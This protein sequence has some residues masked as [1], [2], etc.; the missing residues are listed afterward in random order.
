MSRSTIVGAVDIGTSKVMVLVAE[1]TPSR[2]MNIIGR[3]QSTTVGVKKGEIIDLRSVSDSV[4]A[5][6]HAAERSSSAQIE[7]VYLSMTG[8]HLRG[9]RHP[10]ATTINSSGNVVTPGDIRRA[11]ENAKS[12]ALETGEVYI[13]HI[14]NGFIL[15]GRPTENPLSRQGSHLES[16]YW[17]VAADEDKVKD[18]MTVINGF[19]LDVD[20]IVISSLASGI[21]LATEAEKRQGVLVVDIGKGVTDYVLYRGGRVLQTGVIPV[22]GE[23]ITNDLSLGLR[24]K[25][26]FAESLKRRAARAMVQKDDRNQ[27]VPLV[28]DLSIGDSFHSQLT[29]NKITHARLEELFIILKNQLGSALTRNS[30]PGG[31]ILTGGVA[32]TPLITDLAEVTLDVPVAIGRSPDWVRH[33]ELREPEYATV[34]G[35]LYSALYDQQDEE[36]KKPARPQGRWLQKVAGLFG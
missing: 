24:V 36:P 27:K 4:H 12:K 7:R 21:L 32:K 22:G 14:R 8:S 9:F 5:A 17:H 20:D 31:L 33:A 23:H 34:L 1:M 30:L 18:H 35:L 29:I 16:L 26:K 19:G 3:G 28:G 10:G 25:S 15:D 13:H 6:I 11:V 2:S